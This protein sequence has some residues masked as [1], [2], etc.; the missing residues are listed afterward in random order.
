MYF[1]FFFYKSLLD[2][3]NTI[4]DVLKLEDNYYIIEFKHTK[5]HFPH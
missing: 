2:N 5:N 1:F 4:Y 3:N